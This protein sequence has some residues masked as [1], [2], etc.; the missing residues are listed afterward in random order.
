MHRPFQ[1]VRL[2][3]EQRK[4]KAPTQN[5]IKNEKKKKKVRKE[6]RKEEKGWEKVKKKEAEKGRDLL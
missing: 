4:P 2:V 5:K 3:A 6:R 1:G